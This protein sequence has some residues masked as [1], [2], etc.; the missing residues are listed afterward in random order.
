MDCF[1]AGVTL[2]TTV[3]SPNLWAT[4]LSLHIQG[5]LITE[6]HSNNAGHALAQVESPVFRQ[7]TAQ[8]HTHQV[9]DFG[10]C[11]LLD[12]IHKSFLHVVSMIGQDQCAIPEDI[13]VYFNL[14]RSPPVPIHNV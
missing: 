3:F 9:H 2:L 11:C 12:S 6:L 1:N 14:L 5:R 13:T 10:R 7:Q 4:T 8:E